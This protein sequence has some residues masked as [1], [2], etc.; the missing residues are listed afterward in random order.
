MGEGQVITV[1]Q[2][3]NRA[4]SPAAV[5]AWKIAMTEAVRAGSALVEREHLFIGLYSLGK[6]TLGE[7]LDPRILHQVAAEKEALDFPLRNSGTD[8]ASLRQRVRHAL[9]RGPVG[10]AGD[11]IHRS[12][13]CR[14]CF[15]RAAVLADG[16]EVTCVHLLNALLEDPGSVITGIVVRKSCAALDTRTGPDTREMG[17]A[18][19]EFSRSRDSGLNLKED[20]SSS[21]QTLGSLSRSSAEYQQLLRELEEKSFRLAV[22]C[23]RIRDIA[24]VLEAVNG[25][26]PDPD[27]KD[28]HIASLSGQLAYMQKEGIVLGE[29]SARV[30]HAVLEELVRKRAGGRRP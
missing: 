21:R 22:I 19:Q 1:Y 6:V 8:A 3:E 2:R 14:R 26:A 16:R 29:L 7:N 4:L 20:I 17:R 18:L 23:L 12:Q 15:E 25:L 30:V 27:S 11:V 24:G 10:R 5:I 13:D 28:P 9:V